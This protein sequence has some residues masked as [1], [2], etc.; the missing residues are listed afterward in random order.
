MK[1]FLDTAELD[2]IRKQLADDG[3]VIACF[4]GHKHR[5]R[6][7]VYD[8]THYITMA[9]TH[10]RASYATVEISDHL[11]ITGFG[12]Q[13]SYQLPLLTQQT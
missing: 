7:T 9:A 6:W 12:G 2:E 8:R 4:F 13:R 10:W 11:R 5:N 3:R 1:I